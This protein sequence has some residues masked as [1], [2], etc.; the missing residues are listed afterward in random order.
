MENAL[1]QYPNNLPVPLTRFI[2]REHDIA[3]VQK[4]L[5]DHRLVT[6]TGPGGCGKT[7]LALRIA[8]DC[9]PAYEDGVWLV[10]FAPLSDPAFITQ[11]V[12]AVF[13]VRE[14]PGVALSQSVFEYLYSRHLLLVFDNCEHLITIV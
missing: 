1:I 14:Y 4:S 7:R 11:A 9:L 5:N 10:E 3:E 8:S 2:G 13:G 12:A 6:L